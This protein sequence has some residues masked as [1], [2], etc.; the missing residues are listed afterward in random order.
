MAPVV[1]KPTPQKMDTAATTTTSSLPIEVDS[2][3]VHMDR[4]EHEKLEWMKDLPK[5]SEQPTSSGVPARFDFKG[6]LVSRTADIP[7]TAAL[8]H[9]GEEPE[10]AGYTL[11]ELFQLARSTILQQRVIA[12]QT[13][14]N[15]TRQVSLSSYVAQRHADRSPRIRHIRASSTTLFNYLSFRNSWKLAWYF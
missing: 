13:L 7:V 15:I 2:R 3:W 10:A 8:H 4:I 11:E 9:H 1:M 14:S 12:L 5:L 6:A